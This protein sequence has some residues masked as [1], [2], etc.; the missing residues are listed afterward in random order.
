[1]PESSYV[2]LDFAALFDWVTIQE[3]PA[4]SDPARRL[5]VV[6][7]P[8]AVTTQDH[9]PDL[10]QRLTIRVFGVVGTCNL[11]TLGNWDR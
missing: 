7:V 5:E 2:P 3:M 1:M 6:H 8:A 11:T 4:R 10:Q 9:V